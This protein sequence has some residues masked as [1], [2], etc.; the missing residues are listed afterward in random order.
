MKETLDVLREQLSDPHRKLTPPVKGWVQRVCS[1][2]DKAIK[3]SIGMPTFMDSS[4]LQREAPKDI[5][6]LPLDGY[7]LIE[8]TC[9]VEKFATL[10]TT[11][12]GFYA[13]LLASDLTEFVGVNKVYR[14]N[15]VTS[16]TV[17]RA[18]G[19]VNQSGFA[20][21]SVPVS[22]GASGDNILPIWSENYTPLGQ[23]FAGVV[24]QFPLGDFP[25]YSSV[26]GTVILNHFTALGGAGG[27][28]GV[29]VV[30]HV[31]LETL[32]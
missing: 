24:T 5:P 27:I 1:I 25:L 8:R 23:G 20:G 10:G 18:E 31:V 32:I 4:T 17:P 7:Q 21:V 9:L 12:G 29:L 2:Y 22:S 11:A 28:T 6:T 15:K 13:S 26:E 16:W 3:A 14:I 19:S 30:F